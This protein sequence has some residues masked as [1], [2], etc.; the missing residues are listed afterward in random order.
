MKYL[1]VISTLLLVSLSSCSGTV[2]RKLNFSPQESIRVAVLPFARVDEEGRVTMEDTSVL[3]DGV[4]LVSE[5]QEDD[6]ADLV[7]QIVVSELRKSSLDI[8]STALIDLELPHHGYK[9]TN[10]KL[11]R[12]KILATKPAEI[13]K[14]LLNCDAVL[15]GKVTKWDRS[16]YGVQSINT[17]GVELTLRSINGDKTLFYAKAEDSE[18]RGISK[19]PTGYSSIVIEPIKGL[20]SEIIEDLARQVVRSALQPFRIKERPDFLES[21]PPS[22]FATS[23]S[24]SQ[25]K[26]GRGKPLIVLM[27]GTP[28]Q[29]ASFSVGK[30]I[31]NVPMVE[32][33]EGHYYGEYYP[34]ESDM[35]QDEDIFVKVTDKFGRSTEQKVKINTVSLK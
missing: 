25:G 6:P 23:H 31:E 17:V 33:E 19:G 32:R 2:E 22:I 1:L 28:K 26:L 18:S 24:A 13:C 30:L 21:E 14:H 9:M 7:R 3:V 35:F 11:D 12:P 5:V 15:Y 8:V 16:Y 10:G 29:V 27:F 20:S 34:L 4:P